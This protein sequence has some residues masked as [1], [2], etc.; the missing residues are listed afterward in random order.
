MFPL[1]NIAH[2]GLRQNLSVI[3]EFHHSKAVPGLYAGVYTG[4]WAVIWEHQ[5]HQHLM[6][7]IL[8]S[9]YSETCL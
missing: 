7:H 9:L 8:Q 3:A 1:K 4:S 6:L 5:A 2:K